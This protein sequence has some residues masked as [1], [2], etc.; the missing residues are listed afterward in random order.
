[1]DYKETVQSGNSY[2][3]QW[4]V[5]TARVFDG[6]FLF[7]KATVPDGTEKLPRGVFLKVDQT[8][9]KA[10]LIKTAELHEAIDDQATTVKVKKGALLV[11]TDVLGTGEKA[12]TV[13][14]IDTSNEDYDSFTIGANALGALDAGAVLQTYDAAGASGKSAVNPDGLN[15]REVELDAQPS[16]SVIY[17]VDGIVTSRLPQVATSAI[18]TALKFCQFLTT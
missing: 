7:D 16:C 14:T 2:T 17:A 8:E 3:H 6:G 18:K 11:A 10:S 12:V 1:M 13:G 4:D 9:R 15:Y 5:A